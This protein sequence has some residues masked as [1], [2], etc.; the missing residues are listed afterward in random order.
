MTDNTTLVIALDC[1]TRAIEGV[2]YSFG[3]RKIPVIALSSSPKP[4]AFYSRYVRHS[5]QS[6]PVSR[7]E[8]YLQFLL[9]LPH[10]GVLLYS[11]DASAAFVNKHADRLKKA[12]F[13]LNT[14]SRE[15]FRRGFDKA[16]LARAA[17]EVGVPVIPTIEVKTKKDFQQAWQK[18]DNPI[19]LKATKLAGGKFV[20][21]NKEEELEEAFLHMDALVK[22]PEH[23]H[24][25]SGLIAQEFIYY[26]YDEIYCCESYYTRE[27][28]AN[29]FLSIHKI[30]PNINRDGTAGGRLFAGET[31]RDEAL[32]KH[33]ETLL[34]HLGWKGMAHL[35]WIYSKKYNAYLLCEINPRLPGFSNFLTKVHFEMAYM[36]YADLCGLPLPE[37]V[38]EKSLYFEALRMPGDFTT[39]IY[40]IAKG[41]LPLKPFVASYLQLLTFKHKVCFDILY[42]S[43]PAFTLKS[44][45]EHF[46]YVLKRPFRFLNR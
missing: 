39:G 5:Y 41:Y 21:V 23:R 2:L 12:G 43:D 22:A 9:A 38:F 30:R 26:D 8:E 28:R 20:L 34:N 7:E 11:D 31:I 13:L 40:A 45:S 18:L 35:D 33:T 42:K 15:T 25:Q 3:K 10:R 4:P 14:P 37:P 6:P 27:A 1:D 24:M 46:F 36:Y 17:E 29:G 19:I 32:E 16:L 44:W